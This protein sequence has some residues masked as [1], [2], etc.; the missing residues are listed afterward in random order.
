MSQPSKNGAKGRE[1]T[2]MLINVLNPCVKCEKLP[3]RKDE[4]KYHPKFRHIV[5]MTM[6]VCECG[7]K[8][9]TH[10]FGNDAIADWNRRNLPFDR[11]ERC[12][13]WRP[14][15]ANKG[16]D[17]YCYKYYQVCS[18]TWFCEDGERCDTM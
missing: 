5:P 9:N 7:R 13:F 11:C 10:I 6:Y 17:S 2:A 14:F 3:S 15:G 16:N 12:K 8:T 18:A 4:M 1:Y